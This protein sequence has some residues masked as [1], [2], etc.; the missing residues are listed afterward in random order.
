MTKLRRVASRRLPRTDKSPAARKSPKTQPAPPVSPRWVD[1]WLGPV[2]GQSK[3]PGKSVVLHK[4]VVAAATTTDDSAQLAAS[5]TVPG[6]SGDASDAALVAAEVA[7]VPVEILQRAKDQGIKVIACR[8]S[9]TDVCTE[10][11]GVTPR[12]WP[13]GSTWDSVPGLYEPTRRAVVVATRPGA[14]ESAARHVPLS[15]EGEGAY[16][17]FLH[18]FAH[19]LDYRHCLPGVDSSSRAFTAAYAADKA[20]LTSHSETYLLQPGKAGQEECF[21]ET[22]DRFF[23]G[24]ATLKAELPHLYAF[25][26]SAD[27]KLGGSAQ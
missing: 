3:K 12:G 21:A 15:G 25:W 8:D 24:D 18:E 11:K 9:V 17:L 7:R 27:A 5:M 6:G 23:A 4:H 20:S 19:S 14:T 22:F 16:D 1:T 26:K 2:E 13:P 10:L